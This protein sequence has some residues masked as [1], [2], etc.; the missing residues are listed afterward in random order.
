MP[1]AITRAIVSVNSCTLLQG[2]VVKVQEETRETVRVYGP[3][4][5]VIDRVTV[6][7]GV[8]GLGHAR[9]YPDSR[10]VRCSQDVRGAGMLTFSGAPSGWPRGSEARALAFPG[11]V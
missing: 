10:L 3:A 1:S 11:G 4:G 8:K 6:R 2:C 9:Y 7:T 5:L